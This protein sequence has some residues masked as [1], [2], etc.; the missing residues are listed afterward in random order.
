MKYKIRIAAVSYLN[1]IPFIYGIENSPF[2]DKSDYELTRYIPSACA[3]KVISKQAD[4]GLVPVA[5]IP[6]IESPQ[7][8]SDFCIGANGAV[9]TVLLVSQVPLIR[10]K[11][12]LLDYQSMTSVN[13]VQV[14]AKQFWK[15]PLHFK[16]GGI[17]YESEIKG[18]TA[19]VIIGDR[20]FELDK[21][22]S[23]CYDLSAEWK[24][25]TNLPFVFATWVANRAIPDEFVCRFNA[26]CQFGLDNKGMALTAFTANKPPI[27]FDYK[28]YLTKYI[29][30][31]F[32]PKKREALSLFL[33]Y[34]QK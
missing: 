33:S 28:K 6:K 16:A 8:I 25:Y 31:N 5:A 3:E 19:G 22:Y 7:L 14:L 4:I 24:K 11:N 18:A 1:T 12:I 10:I 26:A 34:L 29:S 15:L 20:T 17:G 30:Y 32:D 13:L 21:Q 23:Y 9:K 2:L 27:S